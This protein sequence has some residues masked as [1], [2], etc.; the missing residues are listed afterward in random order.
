M[1]AVTHR[2]LLLD[3]FT[4][5]NLQGRKEKPTDVN[6]EGTL[7]ELLDEAVKEESDRDSVVYRDLFD[8]RLMN[9]LMPPGTG[10]EGI[11][12]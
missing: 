1:S 6:L 8:T 11:L 9:C 5:M 4:R 7:N 2:L 10:S 3:V 12:G